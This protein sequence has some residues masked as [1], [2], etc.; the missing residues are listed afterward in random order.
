MFL[1]EWSFSSV[2]TYIISSNWT[3]YVCSGF[4]L[5]HL[6]MQSA[7]FYQIFLREKGA[8]KWTNLSLLRKCLNAWL[9]AHGRKP[10][11]FLAWNIWGGTGTSTYQLNGFRHFP[12]PWRS[13]T[14]WNRVQTRGALKIA[15]VA[16]MSCA[17]VQGFC[18]KLTI[19]HQNWF[20][21]PCPHITI[22]ALSIFTVWFWP[23]P[24]N[25]QI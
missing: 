21:F 3:I 9:S 12:V 22:Y 24:S 10:I 2:S 14:G 1:I 6:V 15:G 23:F 20:R 8:Q 19:Y 25:P 7:V 17:V 11:S 4:T 16:R 18:T 5:R 13:S